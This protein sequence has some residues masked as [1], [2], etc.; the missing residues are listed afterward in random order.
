VGY[1]PAD[2]PQV[3]VGAI[4]EHGGHGSSAAAPLVRKVILSY[5]GHEVEDT[6]QKK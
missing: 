4:I 1:A 6:P 2:E 5:L 3:V